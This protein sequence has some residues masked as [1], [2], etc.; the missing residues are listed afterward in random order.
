MTPAHPFRKPPADG[1]G[2]IYPWRP[3][4]SPVFPKIVAIVLVGGGL[5]LLISTVRV[6]VSTP[7]R[8]EPRR[9]AVIYLRDDAQGRALR[10]RAREGGPFPTRFEPMG[11]D[12]LAEIE[13]RT[14][15]DALFRARRYVPQLRDLP[16]DPPAPGVPLAPV[17]K[18][19]FPERA[20]PAAPPPVADVRLAPVAYPL[21]SGAGAALPEKLP[22]FAPPVDAALAAASWRFLLRLDAAGAVRE[23]ISLANGGE[24][25]TAA[26]EAWLREIPFLPG[27]K[28][29]DRWIALGI[30]FANQPADGPDAR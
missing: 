7:E 27:E 30:G 5:V 23:C 26:L 11:W 10:L 22:G 16:D 9:A 18:S 4:K 1:D 2:W 19:F 28:S 25:G 12:G 3:R 15:D 13:R 14:M 6:R 29:A 8:T 21:S 24:P 17:G 20:A